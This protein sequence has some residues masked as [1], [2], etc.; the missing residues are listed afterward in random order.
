MPRP[1]RLAERHEA[2][3]SRAASAAVASAWRAGLASRARVR[4]REATRAWHERCRTRPSSCDWSRTH[5]AAAAASH[6]SACQKTAWP[7]VG[8]VTDLY[9]TW[10]KARGDAVAR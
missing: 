4:A 7:A 9:G 1:R 3:S 2:R 6:S 8:T 10:A 5:G